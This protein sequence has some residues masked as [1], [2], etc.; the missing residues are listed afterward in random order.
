MAYQQGDTIVAI[1][2]PPGEG[3]VGILRLSGPQALAIATTLCGG[4]KVK[5]LMPRH[6]H[7]RRFHARDRSVIDHGIALYFP[8]PHSYTGE[9]VV[10]LQGHGSPLALASLL[11]EAIALGAR[12]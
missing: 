8:A 5:A 12:T 3:G 6:A 4:A 9:T 10:E 7:F 2:T 1:A 11:S